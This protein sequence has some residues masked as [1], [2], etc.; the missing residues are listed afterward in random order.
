MNLNEFRSLLAP[1]EQV[2]RNH[3]PCP[4]GV[5]TRQRWY[6]KKT[7]DGRR[8]VAFCH[9]CGQK[10]V[11]DVGLTGKS[12]RPTPISSTGARKI[13]LPA[14]MEMN[15]SL[16]P[17]EARKWVLKSGLD[18][19]DCKGVGAG[20][21]YSQA[22]L[23]LPIWRDSE[24]EGFQARSFNPKEIKY[25]TYAKTKPLRAWYNGTRE[26]GTVVVCED[27]LSAWKISQAGFTGFACLGS[28]GG[29]SEI[30]ALSKQYNRLVIWLDN[31]KPE[32]L[33]NSRRLLRYGE[34][35]FPETGIVLGSSDPKRHSLEDIRRTVDESL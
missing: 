10:G 8:I 13:Q 30:F 20:Y 29:A 19:Q 32:V 34:M 27:L 31:D 6:I 5:D 14:D 17:E 22:R 33:K 35:F 2:R 23:I 4:A 1:G 9:N 21:S 11:L 25:L 3:E 15:P 28:A 24:L 12:I 18:F 7:E 16:W 26:P